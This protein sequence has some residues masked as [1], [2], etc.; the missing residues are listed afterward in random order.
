MTADK[1]SLLELV[2]AV[3]GDAYLKVEESFGDGFVRL[4]TSEAER[5]QA[6]HDIRGVEDIV[7]ELLRNARDA[8]SQ[9]MYVATTRDGDTRLLTII[10]DGVGVPPEMHDKIFEPRVTSKLETM[11]I[12]RWGVHGRGMALYSV[13]QNV[14]S[15]RILASATHRGAAVQILSDCA[16]LGERADQSSWPH[17]ERDA[18]GMARVTK[19]PHNI[20]RRVVEF[21]CEHPEVDVFLGS[22][23][24]ILATLA[25]LARDSLD[26]RD[27]LFA[28]DLE[29]LPVWQRPG[30]A[31]DAADLVGIARD[32]GLPVSERTA[33]RIL[34]GELVSL[35]SIAQLIHV[36]DEPTPAST[37]DIYRD[38]RGLKVHHTDLTE[39][40]REVTQAFDRLAERYYLHLRGEPRIQVSRDGIT[41]RF[42]IDKED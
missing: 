2:S 29:R 35:E 42:E 25:S 34:A 23:A 8:R 27:L 12:D 18:D 16:T 33:H 10:D 17:V 32:I 4:R 30:A 37:P 5:R 19:G 26:T 41:V 28:D 9:R 39:F 40:R 7:V 21:A 11:V 20:I 6:K 36:D 3:S 24:E 14:E 15:A 1:D 38:R 31:A 22:P 13:R